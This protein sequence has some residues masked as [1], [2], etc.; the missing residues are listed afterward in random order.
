MEKC[1]YCVQRI[2]RARIDAKV[3]DRPR[4]DGDVRT[5]CQAV[6]PTRAIVFGDGNDAASLVARV[7]ASPRTYALLGEL[8][9]RPR[10]EYLA[11]IDTEEA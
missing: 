6:C 9:T 3:A 1:T 7:K 10:T 2:A 8:G 5:A 4:R 11:A